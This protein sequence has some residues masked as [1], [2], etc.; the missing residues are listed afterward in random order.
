MVL[1]PTQTAAGSTF[2]T[3]MGYISI[4]VGVFDS[5][6]RRFIIYLDTDWKIL[7]HRKGRKGRKD[8]VTAQFQNPVILTIILD[9]D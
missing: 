6:A 1:N 4:P 5:C 2:Q 7:F 8:D 3:F 9:A